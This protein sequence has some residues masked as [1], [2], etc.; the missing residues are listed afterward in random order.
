MT[1]FLNDPVFGFRTACI[2]KCRVK[3]AHSVVFSKSGTP[4]SFVWEMTLGVT[5]MKIFILN[6][7][8]FILRVLE[9]TGV[10]CIVG[11]K[12]SFQNKHFIGKCFN[13]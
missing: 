9:N 2:L 1:H 10:S 12:V 6:V 4:T 8:L 11:Y 3:F 7:T 5:K 13:K